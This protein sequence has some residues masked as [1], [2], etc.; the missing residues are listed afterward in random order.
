MRDLLFLLPPEFADPA[1]GH[2]MFYCPACAEIRG[3][4][5]H[6]PP[7]GHALDVRVV[8]F[9][10]PRAEVA[11]LLGEPHPGCPVLVLAE[12]RGTPDGIEVRTASTGLRYI[13]DPRAI[14]RYLAAV[15]GGSGPHP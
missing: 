5:A 7:P 15:H 9:P 1:A 2:G 11:A 13:D 3:L 4:L 6:R 14:G 12:A 8:D 10:R